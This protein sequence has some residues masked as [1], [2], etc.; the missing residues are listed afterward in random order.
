[1]KE[2]IVNIGSLNDGDVKSYE[3]EEGEEETKGETTEFEKLF[4]RV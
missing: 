1:M 2:K 4:Q 3:I